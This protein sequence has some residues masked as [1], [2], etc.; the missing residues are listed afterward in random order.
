MNEDGHSPAT[1]NY[2]YCGNPEAPTACPFLK[3]EPSPSKGLRNTVDRFK[4]LEN[5]DKAD[6]L[7][8]LADVLR[9]ILE[10]DR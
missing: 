8:E 3:D 5:Q 10:T 1:C 7:D 4:A 2:R 6:L 9:R